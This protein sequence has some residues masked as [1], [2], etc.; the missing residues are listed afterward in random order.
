MSGVL[1]FYI[2]SAIIEWT[3]RWIGGKAR[4]DKIR[5][6][7]AWPVIV[8]MAILLVICLDLLVLGKVAFIHYSLVRDYSS[9]EVGYY[10]FSYFTKYALVLWGGIIFLKMLGQVQGFSA[11]KAFVNCMILPSIII[12]P[13]MIYLVLDYLL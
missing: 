13:I 9:F 3:G 8:Q 12:V 10:W 11:W 1:S 2:G 6:A 7:C 4:V 5:C